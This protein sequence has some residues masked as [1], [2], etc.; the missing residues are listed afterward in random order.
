MS[1]GEIF[2]KVEGEGEAVVLIHGLSDNLNYWESLAV[3]LKKDYKVIRFD[4][5]GHGKSQL[6]R[7]KITIDLLCDDLYNLLNDLKIKKV[8][9]LGFSLGGLV[10]LDFT[11]RY[12]E[13]VSSLILMSAFSHS[14]NHIS[15]VF[16]QFKRALNNSFEEFYDL[17]LPMTLCPEVIQNNKKELEMLKII[18]AQ[19]SNSKAY[20]ESVDACLLFNTF[21]K[22]CEI[23][24]PVLI[25]AGSYDEIVLLNMQENLHDSIKNSK[26]II[27]DN[28][29]HNL[30]V[31]KNNS[32][33]LS[34]LRVF[35]K[36]KK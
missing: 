28:V 4:L 21:D 36:N 6:G 2:F 15:N 11:I 26:L 34:V 16:N 8:N 12:P 9:L 31:G 23:N 7:D 24:C 22:L 35:L 17:I 1:V 25:L 20:I 13:Y 29:K 14:D 19:N 30:L 18:S 33:V 27:F 3:N 5:R 32:E 10:A